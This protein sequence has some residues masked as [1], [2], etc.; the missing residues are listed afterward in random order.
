MKITSYQ[1]AAQRTSK[2]DHDRL[3]AGCLGLIGE[4][5]ELVDIIKKRAF[6]GLAHDVAQGLMLDE[7]GDVLWYIAEACAGIGRDIAEL[8]ALP[9]AQ[10]PSNRTLES[11]AVRLVLRA[12][13]LHIA[14]GRIE[15]DEYAFAVA[16]PRLAGIY[17]AAAEICAALGSTVEQ[18]CGRNIRK[19]RT[20][21]PQGF[22]AEISSARYEED[23]DA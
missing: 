22:D 8:D 4:S 13:E 19:L 21:Y 17:R 6:Q 2:G 1:K 12:C 16:W 5:G 3:R 7:I 23:E 9:A 11:R 14:L 18:V 15:T 20:R 10:E